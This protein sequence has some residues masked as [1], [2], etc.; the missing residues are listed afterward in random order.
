MTLRSVNDAPLLESFRVHAESALRKLMGILGAGTAQQLVVGS[1]A[2]T[3]PQSVGSGDTAASY[4]VA[5]AEKDRY[6]KD[7]DSFDTNIAA[8]AKKS[9][10]VT[11]MARIVVTGLRDT[12][13]SILDTVPEKPPIYTQMAYIDKIGEKVDKAKQEVA[14]AWDENNTQSEN[15]KRNSPE[16]GG[17]GPSG[18]N[19]ASGGLG[20][21]GGSNPA[22]FSQSHRSSAPGSGTPANAQPISG[23]KKAQASDIYRYLITK[24]GF[25]P[26]QAAGILGNMQVESEFNT[27]AYN[28]GE[29]AIGLCQWEGGRRTM[30]ERFAASQGKPV[31]DWQV[32]VDYMMREM[33]GGES[34]AYAR[35]KAT[36]DAASAASVFDQ[37]YERS[38]GEARGQR[39]ANAASIYSSMSAISV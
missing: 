25:T 4:Q 11:G 23:G 20:S 1:L 27:A 10:D 30:L 12:I 16:T 21:G 22:N 15:V 24:Y 9:A 26:A 2:G 5:D 36:G 19:T 29:G 28:P 39:M 3:P 13:N 17:S 18:F 32:Q 31:T 7:L 6:K 35:L 14:D 34:G 8:I 37:Y 33:Q 38:S